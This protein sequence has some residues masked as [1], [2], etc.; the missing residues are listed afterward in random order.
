MK[1]I[2]RNINIFVSQIK[3]QPI[4]GTLFLFIKSLFK[5]E[6][7]A[8]YARELEVKKGAKLYSRLD[9]LIS[10]GSLDDIEHA[11]KTMH[12]L[13]WEF[14]CDRYDGVKDFFVYKK[15]GT[16]GHISWIYYKN[17]PNRILDLG[18]DEGEI[19]YSLTLPQFRGKGIYPAA[20][21]RIQQY[22]EE[23]G[24]KRV[25]IC[26]K[27]DNLPS[28]KGIEKAGFKFVTCIDLIK[29]GGIQLSKR[30]AAGH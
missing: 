16:I 11:R 19:K 20:L 9:N 24:Y 30:Y 15:N 3:N 23:R 2:A 7:I 22:L 6:R 14:C 1:N 13:I 29:I 12:P 27:H 18:T 28:I 5:K 21:L 17:D 4:A 10:K 25:Y 8:I 26:A